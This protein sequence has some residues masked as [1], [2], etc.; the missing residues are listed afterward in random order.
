MAQPK[1]NF[2]LESLL[3]HR[4]QLEKEQQRR[5]AEIQQQIQK[6]VNEIRESEERIS[7][8]NRALAAEKLVGK[9]DMQY[10]AH[11]KRFV[12]NLHMK[13]VLTMQQISRVEQLLAAARA[14]LLAAARARK[15]IEK[16]REK[17]FRR[18]REEQDRKDSA[19]MDEIGTQTAIREMLRVSLDEQEPG[20]PA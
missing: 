3:E 16:L 17:Q 6:L 4:K 13:I 14:E 5:V 9:L 1:F 2:R 19:L 10:I 7:S 11:E 12:G 18:W 15:V 20:D 8:E